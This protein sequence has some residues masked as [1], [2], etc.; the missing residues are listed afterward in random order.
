MPFSAKELVEEYLRIKTQIEERL[1]FF[2]SIRENASDNEIFYELVFCILT[3]QSRPELCWEAVLRLKDA[4][5]FSLKEGKDVLEHLYGVRFKYKKSEFVIEARQWMKSLPNGLKSYLTGFKK[6]EDARDALVKNVK[7]IGIKEAGHFLRNIGIGCEL[8]ILD[9]HVLRFLVAAKVI[10]EI[11]S[12]L[13]ISRYAEIEKKMRM[14]AR[15]IKIPMSH[16]DFVLFY[17]AT[18]KIFK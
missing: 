16:L 13:T 4:D 12:S 2:D 5:I 9:R 11:P 14:Y 8:A 6:I 7:G 18:G 17:R 15:K 10:A 1:H 3:P